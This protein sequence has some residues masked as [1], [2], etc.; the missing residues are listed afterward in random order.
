MKTARELLLPS[1][2]LA[3]LYSALSLR[4]S[5][6]PEGITETMFVWMLLQCVVRKDKH[7]FLVWNSISKN[8]R[9]TQDKKFRVRGI[10][11]PISFVLFARTRE[12]VG[13]VNFNIFCR[14][15]SYRKCLA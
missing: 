1:S 7:H 15:E 14:T 3:S 12:I 5:L 4:T 2:T 9:G 10:Y 6:I 13:K 11:F 8:A